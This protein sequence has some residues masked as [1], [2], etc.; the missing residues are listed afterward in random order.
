M[1]TAVIRGRVVEQDTGAPVARATVTLTS[2]ALRRSPRD[3]PVQTQTDVDGRFEFTSLPAGDY[4]IGVTAGELRATHL[5]Q[6]YGESRPPQAGRFPRPRPIKLADG[7][8]REDATVAL[9]RAFAIEGRVVN[10]FGEPMAG[11]YLQVRAASTGQQVGMA[12]P[13][14]FSSDDRGA[15]RV[16]GLSPGSYTV[17]ANA[18]GFGPSTRG[19][20]ERYVETCHPAALTE[21]DAQPVTVASGD[22]AG[23]DIRLQR[24]RTFTVTG[25]AFDSNGA[26]LQQG[27]V[28]LMRLERGGGASG[29]GLELAPDGRFVARGLT[30]GEYA[31]RADT[32]RRTGPAE[33]PDPSREVALVPFRIDGFDLDGLVIATSRMA[34]VA[35][36]LVFED[37]A[38]PEGTSGMRVLAS[39]D[40]SRA[41]VGMM[42]PPAS[43]QVQ[44]DLTF[45]LSGLFGP[46]VIAVNSASR[47]W[48][49]KSV[50]YQGQDIMDM[51]VDFTGAREGDRVDIVL[52]NRV[53]RLS[54]TVTDESGTL[55]SG[56]L[57]IVLPADR[58]RWGPQSALRRFATS[59][60]RGE[61]KIG[62]F[63]AG[64]YLIAAIDRDEGPQGTPDEKY[65][66][67]I[68]AVADRL[69]LVE[70]EEQVLQLR[71]RKLP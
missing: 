37:A 67:R 45:Q 59:E 15:Y 68:A 6:A 36:R 17:C 71:L 64:E 46:T 40:R 18:R 47:N 63:R 16:Y 35:G 8:I 7:E 38:P 33:V 13:Y 54:G 44:D 24:S 39:P 30:P 4:T 48:I 31:I 66:A 49:V 27:Q 14:S 32:W 51:A 69:T 9:W 26:P 62:P 2:G 10:E 60:A 52:T 5:P 53:A 1:G 21:A 28:S 19:L 34:S 3:G 55:V 70:S 58:A 57:I 43:A 42:G 22:I 23:V 29:S 41:R 11:V 25:T 50:R 12:G 56:A 65:Y 20:E 61:F